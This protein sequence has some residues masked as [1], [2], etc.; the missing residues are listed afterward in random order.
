MD[1][2]KVT[3]VQKQNIDRATAI[4]HYQS[5]DLLGQMVK[6]TDCTV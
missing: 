3:S 4:E 1:I 5:C 2:Y 6:L